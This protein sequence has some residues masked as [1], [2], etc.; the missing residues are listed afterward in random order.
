MKPYM[1]IF[2]LIFISLIGYV[3]A[4]GYH[5]FIQ[6]PV[7]KYSFA[8]VYFL[9]FFT[10][11]TGFI[12][13]DYLPIKL[14]NV[15]SFVGFTFLMVVIY[16]GIAFFVIDVLR[17][18]DHFFVHTNGVLVEKYRIWAS[19]AAFGV[20]LVAL[21]AGNYRFNHPKVVELNVSAEQTNRHKQLRIVMVSDLHLGSNI[22]KDKVQQ[23][24][25]LI[26]DQNPDVVFFVGDIADRGIEPFVKQ[27]MYEDLQQIKAKYGA[28]GVSGN[29]EYYSFN[30]EL[31]Y[32]YYE[33]AGIKMLFDQAVLIDSSF[34]VLGRD[35]K[36]NPNRKT[37]VEIAQG[38][39]HQYPVILL[40]HQ[41]FHLEEAEENGITMQFSGHTHAGQFFPGNI[42]VNMMYEL[43]YGYLKKGNT[44]YYVSSGLGI[45]GPLYRVGT[46][47]ELVVVNLL[48]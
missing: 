45:W 27:Q 18:I 46:Q 47:S 16:M 40:D 13:A 34:Y 8:V 24:V 14:A 31:N 26:N 6:Y 22:G 32:E 39:D 28:Y 36:T 23:Y 2:L 43:G 9:L 41:P 12:G 21:V 35:D 33:K 4:R 10:M 20:V 25:K 1:I 19:I 48:Y 29:H 15:L 37:L 11:M 7:L 38:L 17:L 44:H 42:I 30:R 5:N 3:F